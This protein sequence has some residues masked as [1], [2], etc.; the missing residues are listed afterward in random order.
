MGS[1]C[2]ILILLICIAIRLESSFGIVRGS[3]SMKLD[4]VLNEAFHSASTQSDKLITQNIVVVFEDSTDEVLNT[5]NIEAFDTFE[6]YHQAFKS[7]LRSLKKESQSEVSEFLNKTNIRSK[8]LWLTNEVFIK[9]A[10]LELCENLGSFDNVVL[11]RKEE[12]LQIH[13]PVHAGAIIE[14]SNVTINAVQWNIDKVKAPSV[15]SQ[16][17]GEGITVGIIDTG[18]RPTHDAL[19]THTGKIT[20]WFDCVAGKS[21]PYDDQGIVITH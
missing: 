11:I 4:P 6:D 2:R 13:K 1:S 19:Q 15:W 21:A 3:R 5:V 17:M 9:D 16:N 8:S 14:R 18:M 12:V 7:E 10:T 20:N